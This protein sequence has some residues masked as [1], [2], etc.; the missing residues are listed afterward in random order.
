LTTFAKQVSIMTFNSGD[1]KLGNYNQ[2]TKPAADSLEGKA[3]ILI[4]NMLVESGWTIVK[5]NERIPEEGNFA[6]EEVETDAGPMDYALIVDGMMIGDVEAKPE[7]KNFSENEKM[8]LDL[9]A[10]HL[11]YNLL[12]ERKHFDTIPFSGKGGWKKANEDFKNNLQNIMERINV[13]MAS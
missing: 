6:V 13:G 9:I 10:N 5:Q 1:L 3:R 7:N 12:I 4:D 8:W 2:L 11:E